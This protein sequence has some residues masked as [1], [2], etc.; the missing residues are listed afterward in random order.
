VRI[1]GPSASQRYSPLA[2]FSDVT[3]PPGTTYSTRYDLIANIRHEGSVEATKSDKIQNEGTN[4]ESS[5]SVHILHKANNQWYNMHDLIVE[6]T[7]HE[8]VPLSEAYIQ[9][10]ERQV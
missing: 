6:E 4:D 10:Y 1:T 7:I 2:F 3:L 8:L 9:I 5:F